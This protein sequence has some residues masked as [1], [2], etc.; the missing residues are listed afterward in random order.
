MSSSA[1]PSAL[2]RPRERVGQ[3]H[4]HGSSAIVL[5][6]DEPLARSVRGMRRGRDAPGTGAV[7]GRPGGRRQAEGASRLLRDHQRPAHLAQHRLRLRRPPH[8]DHQRPHQGLPRRSVP[9][10]AGERAVEGEDRRPRAQER[11]RGRRLRRV[12][13]GAWLAERRRQALFHRQAD[14]ARGQPV[15]RLGPVPHPPARHREARQARRLGQLV[16]GPGHRRLGSAVHPPQAGQDGRR[17]GR[18]LPR[19]ATSA[20]AQG[21]RLDLQGRRRARARLR[22]RAQ[23]TARDQAHRRG[24]R[25]GRRPVPQGRAAGRRRDLHPHRLQGGGRRLRRGR[26]RRRQGIRRP[27][28]RAGQGGRRAP[29]RRDRALRRHVPRHESPD[30]Q[31]RRQRH[32]HQLPRRILRRPPQGIPLAS[33]SSTTTA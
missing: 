21:G 9:P 27:L 26:P 13:P 4:C 5:P 31:A 25:M 1:R 16:E 29:A 23:A 15:W 6:G 20:Y 12:H 30:G 24:R 3:E 2:C 11:C 22:R 28:D 8:R 7:L 33:A 18:G 32:Q 19:H 17:R 10:D 14:P